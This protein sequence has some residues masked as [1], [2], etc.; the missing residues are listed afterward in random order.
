[1]SGLKEGD[2]VIIGPYDM[3]SKTL[4][5]GDKVKVVDQKELY[6]KK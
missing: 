2:E 5:E 6:D 3:V 1:M 4:K